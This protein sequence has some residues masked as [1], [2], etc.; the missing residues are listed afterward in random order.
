MGQCDPIRVAR[1]NEQSIYYFTTTR[2]GRK[3]RERSELRT[4]SEES[5][6]RGKSQKKSK[7]KTAKKPLAEL[8]AVASRDEARRGKRRQ[9]SQSRLGIALWAVQTV[10]LDS[11]SCS[12]S[13]CCCR[14]FIADKKVLLDPLKWARSGSPRLDSARLAS[15]R[16]AS[17]RCA[18]RLSAAKSNLDT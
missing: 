8:V 10:K 12:C 7:E 11:T 17:T 18:A 9:V 5:A 13:C 16:L 1:T 6:S 3:G 2:E 14:I 4:E 15:V